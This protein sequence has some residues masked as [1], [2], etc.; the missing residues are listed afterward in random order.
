MIDHVAY[1][2]EPMYGRSWESVVPELDKF[3]ALLGFTPVTVQDDL[4]DVHAYEQAQ[5][6]RWYTD[7]GECD[8]HIVCKES[9]YWGWQH[10]CVKVERPVFEQCRDSIYLD[11]DSGSGRIWLVGPGGIRVEVRPYGVGSSSAG[12]GG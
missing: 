11:R 5:E 12:V 8:V 6:Q 3:F 7:G 9:L 1:T 4:V 10:F 2:V